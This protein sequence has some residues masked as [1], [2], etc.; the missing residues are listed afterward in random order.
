MNTEYLKVIST[1]LIIKQILFEIEYKTVPGL[2]KKIN[3]TTFHYTP[4]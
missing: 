4:L 2:I 1:H 3:N